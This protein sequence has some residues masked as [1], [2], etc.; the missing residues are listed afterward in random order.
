MRVCICSSGS[1]VVVVKQVV[2]MG[3]MLAGQGSHRYR[4]R[5]CPCLFSSNKKATEELRLSLS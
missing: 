3:S 4:H 2:G 5:Q 1:R